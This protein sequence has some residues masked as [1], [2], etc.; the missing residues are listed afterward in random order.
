NRPHVSS[1][2]LRDVAQEVI[3]SRCT[4]AAPPGVGLLRQHHAG[5]QSS[6]VD[7]RHESR[8]ATAHYQHICVDGLIV[9]GDHGSS[10]FTYESHFAYYSVHFKIDANSH[11]R[12][13]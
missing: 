5:S 9:P 1:V 3:I 11:S 6:C 8:N 12:S 4:T 2:D 10:R 13:S 7:T